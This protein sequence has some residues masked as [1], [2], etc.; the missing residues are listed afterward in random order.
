VPW[1][2]GG[3]TELENLELLCWRH[4]RQQHGDRERPPINVLTDR[5]A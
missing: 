1:S 2:R 3:R 5:A 4:H